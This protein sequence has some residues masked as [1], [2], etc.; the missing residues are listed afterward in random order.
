MNSSDLINRLENS[1][2]ALVAALH[3]V[4][5]AESR[6]KPAPAD[7]SIVEIVNHLVDEEVEDFRTRLRLTLE[8]PLADWPPIDPKGAAIARKYQQRDLGE[9][10]AR[11]ESARSESL[12]WLRSLRN[13][14][15]NQVHT[16]PK[17]GSMRAGDLLASWAAHDLLHLRQITKRRYQYLRAQVEPFKLDYAG[18]W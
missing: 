18:E 15:L 12:H 13:L 14:S 10:V 5:E 4:S 3:G 9:S 6:W 1:A 17:L 8:S 7:W 2:R 11:F 16:H